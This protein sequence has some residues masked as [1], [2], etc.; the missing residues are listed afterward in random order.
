MGNGKRERGTERNGTEQNRARGRKHLRLEAR[1][2]GAQPMPRWSET[3]VPS[4]KHEQRASRRR[5][6]QTRLA[7]LSP[8]LASPLLSRTRAPELSV[9]TL[10]TVLYCHSAATLPPPQR[11]K[12]A[13][14]DATH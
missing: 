9:V 13:R 11:H 3:E 2:A 8:L 12:R 4:T 1:A 6:G 10:I 7:S 14:R 5:D